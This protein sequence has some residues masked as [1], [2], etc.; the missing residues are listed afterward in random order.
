MLG[1][2]PQVGRLAWWKRRLRKEV[3]IAELTEFCFQTKYIPVENVQQYE[4]TCREVHGEHINVNFVVTYELLEIFSRGV[5]GDNMT[6]FYVYLT[7]VFV[8]I[9]A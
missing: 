2:G 1:T 4:F 8:I 3:L 5:G 9:D 6:A 7:S